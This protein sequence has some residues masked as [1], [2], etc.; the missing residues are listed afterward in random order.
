MSKNVYVL[1]LLAGSFGLSVAVPQ[2]VR[3]AAT[4]LRAG[5]APAPSAVAEAGE[6]RWVKLT[7]AR[8][9]CDKRTVYNDSTTFFLATDAAGA[10]PFVAQFAQVV[11]C[12]AAQANVN[13]AFVPA[14]PG[15][16]KRYGIESDA[17]LR[18]FTETQA[19]K[20]LRM[21]LLVLGIIL[22]VGGG[23]FAFGLRGVLR[24]RR[25]ARP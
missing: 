9:L 13:G 1:L 15:E 25:A 19:P 17:G 21:L 12:E 23:F 2:A 18:F 5:A 11:S 4:L 20:Y 14:R 24:S 3:T 6:G 22:L 10:N 7:D 8:L 16:L